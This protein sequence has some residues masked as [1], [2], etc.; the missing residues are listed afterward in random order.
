VP[1]I[2]VLVVDDSVVIRR[3]VTDALQAEPDIRVVGTAPNGKVAL[4]KIAQLAPDVVTLDIEMPEMDGLTTIREIRKTHAK[5]PVIMFST[6]SV[7]GGAATLEALASGASDYVT[8]PANVGSV[9]ESMTSVREQLIPRIRALTGRRAPAAARPAAAPVRVAAVPAGPP[10]AID[11]LAVG[12]STG[13][14]EALATVLTRMPADL[15]VP[16]VVVQHMPPVFTR[17]FA[18]RLDRTSRLHV[19]EAADGTPLVPGHVYIAPGDRHLEVVRRATGVVTR[20]H[21]GPPECFCRPAVDVLFRS[22]AAAYKGTALALVLTGMGQDGKRGSESLREG[23]SRIV[24]QDEATSVV[25][26][27]PGAVAGAGLAEAV[28]PLDQIGSAVLERI[29]AMRRPQPAGAR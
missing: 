8:K 4:A 24:V 27:M 10:K 1:Q 23:G 5:L 20:L 2:S 15:P 26:G 7:A 6:L 28:L 19:S 17:L 29:T 16:V 14:P 18:E 25:W 9:R 3:L 13:G 22:V 21:D 12:C 11:I